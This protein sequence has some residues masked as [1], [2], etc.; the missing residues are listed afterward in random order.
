M[1][2]KQRSLTPRELRAVRDE[3]VPAIEKYCDDSQQLPVISPEEAER[4]LA[5]TRPPATPKRRSASSSQGR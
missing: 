5:A 2:S 4:V 3:L 1:D